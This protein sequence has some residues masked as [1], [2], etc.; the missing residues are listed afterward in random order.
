MHQRGEDGL[1]LIWA[2]NN[3]LQKNIVSKEVILAEFQRINQN[4]KKRYAPYYV[5]KDGL[6]FK[7]FKVV[8]K[9]RYGVALR[10]VKSYKMKGSYLLTYDFGDHYHTVALVDGEVLD[11]RKTREITGV[12]T[13]RRLV[14]V[15]KVV[16]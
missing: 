16:R 3:A 5:N 7:T 12:D 14:D 1:C 6:D 2:V 8:V 13:P 9:K 10:K 11:S 4:N 15:Y